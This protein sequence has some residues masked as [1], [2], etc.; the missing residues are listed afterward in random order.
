M[1]Y[2]FLTLSH[3]EKVERRRQ[4]NLSGMMAWLSPIVLLLVVYVHRTLLRPL[5]GQI[6]PPQTLARWRRVSWV[7]GTKTFYGGHEFGPLG[8][9]LSGVCYGLWLMVLVFRATGSDYMHLAKAFGHVAVSQLPLIYLL[10]VKTAWSPITLATGWTHERLNVWHRLLGRMAHGLASVH[11]AMYVNFFVRQQVLWKR[12][13]D[14]DVILGLVAFSAFSFL[15]LSSLPV[16]RKRWYHFVFY[17]SHVVL[18]AVLVP[19]MWWHVPYTRFYVGQA[20]L[21]W[22]AGALVRRWGSSAVVRARCV[23]VDGTELVDVVL[24]VPT[25]S[26]FVPGAPGQ[27]LYVHN[28]WGP[29]TPFTI[30]EVKKEKGLVTVRL[31]VRNVGG[32]QTR[33]I[34][35]MAKN[36]TKATEVRVEGPYGDPGLRMPDMIRRRQK[37]PVLMVAGG[38]GATYIIPIYI[39]LVNQRRS[40]AGEDAKVRLVWV[41]RRLADAAW[42]ID[43][44]K[45]VGVGLEECGVD[46]YVTRGSVV[47]D[48]D[49][50][51]Q[52]QPE[53]SKDGVRVHKLGRRPDLT[54]LIDGFFATT[55]S[56]SAGTGTPPSDS[57]LYDARKLRKRQIAMEETTAY[58]CG[59]GSLA[60]DVREAVG[61]HVMVESRKVRW[62]E[63]VF[64][65][66]GT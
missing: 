55:S 51:E 15:W 2:S 66:G 14:R 3:E 43:M 62:V 18:S 20:G 31:I 30:A 47:G 24:E 11:V 45:G 35:D 19:A 49:M 36:S 41:V 7:L 58:V 63:E 26:R 39:T 53:L 64:G 56:E 28:G 9:V 50:E 54:P 32:P 42:G 46:I 16:V 57:R 34:A 33:W 52:W 37:G 61:R 13:R 60:T 12:G 29:R 27:H 10:G 22:A 23:A 40:T 59:P 17:R 5:L 8:V 44:L 21:L 48:G 1:T 38:V 65:F 4:L 25:S 6:V